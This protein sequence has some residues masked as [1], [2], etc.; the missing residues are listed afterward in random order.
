MD[1]ENMNPLLPSEY[2]ALVFASVLGAGTWLSWKSSIKMRPGLRVLVTA[3]RIISIACLAV[4]AFNPGNWKSPGEQKKKEIAI[5]VDR[6]RSMDVKDSG[7]SSRWAEACRLASRTTEFLK[8]PDCI[9]SRT[10]P[11]AE[12]LE[13][14]AE[15]VSDLGG[16]K[17]DGTGTGIL[18]SCSMLLEKYR[19]S[20]RQL[21]AIVLLSD[22]RNTCAG[23]LKET[24][25]ALRSEDVKVHAV[26]IG[27]YVPLKNLS[28]IL[29]R[30]HYTAFPG[31][32]VKITPKVAAMNTGP[33]QVDLTL[34]DPGGKDIETRKLSLEDNSSGTVEFRINFEK[35]GYFSYRLTARSALE[36]SNG[37]DNHMDFHVSVLEK[38]LKI[39]YIEG[40]P[41]WDSKFLA[42][43]LR[44]DSNI[45]LT[46]VHRLS[47]ERYYSVGTDTSRTEESSQ[48]IFPDSIGELLAYDAVIIGKG[49]EYFLNAFRVTLLKEY[50]RDH[51]GAVLFA[52]GRPAESEVPGLDSIE[53]AVWGETIRTD[54]YWEPTPDGEETGLFGDLLPGRA[55]PIWKELPPL[56]SALQVVELKTF[57][58]VLAVGIPSSQIGASRISFPCV[59][60]RKYGKGIVMTVNSEGLWKWDFFP[61]SE[62]AQKFYREFW[63][64]AILWM[65]RHSD[66]MPGQDYSLRLGKRNLMPCEPL[67]ISVSRRRGNDGTA[68]LPL[69]KV[70]DGDKEVKQ[71]PLSENAGSGDSFSAL[72]TMDFPGDYTVALVTEKGCRIAREAFSVGRLPLEKDNL[73]ADVKFLET[74]VSETAGRMLEEKNLDEIFHDELKETAAGAESSMAVWDPHWDTWTV[75]ALMLLV[76]CADIYLRRR[77]GLS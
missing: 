12:G 9:E 33:L 56:T 44:Q 15:T 43:L 10:Y 29:P 46:T 5:L 66:Y 61:V 19:G 34:S 73:S 52:R 57:A 48:P 68:K 18:K 65:A 67:M 31:Q 25:L 13:K 63:I 53:P 70:F 16:L 40:M 28:V 41:Y 74:L 20:E 64:Q 22:G 42:Q 37:S 71:T 32:S 38:K 45:E 30:R 39:I 47:S 72:V 35:P 75:L 50:I 69:V 1:G 60:S 54:F 8:K 2:L 4:I 21:S 55:D 27:G 3:L 51:G 23:D 24:T 76:L 36:E 7:A 11:F 6:S 49:A 58:K 17:P 77:S 14:S 26:A 59:I 62:K